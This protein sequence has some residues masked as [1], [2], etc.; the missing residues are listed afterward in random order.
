M[1]Q[2]SCLVAGMLP[3]IERQPRK[4]QEPDPERLLGL[5]HRW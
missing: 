5:L 2:S 1:S 4:K 3:D